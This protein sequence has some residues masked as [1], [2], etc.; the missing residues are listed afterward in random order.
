MLT[1]LASLVEGIAA[2]EILERD[3][4]GMLSYRGLT[5]IVIIVMTFL[6]PVII[7]NLFIGLA[8][9]VIEKV[10]ENATVTQRQLQI[11][12]YS[13]VDP[14]LT[15]LLTTASNPSTYLTQ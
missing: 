12:L 8:M 1:V 2:E 4:M 6:L 7:I 11:A 13:F 10:C 3:T 14:L 5:Y 15:N 9:G